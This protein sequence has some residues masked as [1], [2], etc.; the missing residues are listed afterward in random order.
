MSSKSLIMTGAIVGSLV[1]GYVPALFGVSSF[2][3]VSLITSG[4]GGVLGIWLAYKITC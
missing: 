2:S 1:G 3:F 4:I